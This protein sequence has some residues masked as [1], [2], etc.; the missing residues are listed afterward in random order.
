MNTVVSSLPEVPVVDY[1]RLSRVYVVGNGKGGVGK[2]NTTAHLGA[3]VALDGARVLLVDLNGQGN[4]GHLL[5]YANTEQDDQGRNLFSAVTTGVPLT[6]IKDVRPGLDVVAGGHYVRMINSVLQGEA[7][8]HAGVFRSHF[9]LALALVQLADQYGL[10]I[11]DSP[12]ENQTL[13]RLA[14][15]AA[16]FVIVPMKTDGLSRIGLRDIARD[17][18]EMREHNPYLMLLAVFVFGSGSGSKKIRRELRKRVSA[19]LGQS[20]DV[21][22]DEFVRHAETVADQ[23]VMYGLLAHELDAELKNNPKL[24]AETARAVAQDYDALAEAVLTRAANRQAEMIE[25]GVW[26]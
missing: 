10:I 11:I 12:P 18:R 16:R 25:Q 14:L 23:S 5:G 19:D 3:L 1:S 2:S 6:P 13:L 9:G 21:L 20:G 26:P 4:I 24:I 7:G 22:L 15:G 17:I 8:T